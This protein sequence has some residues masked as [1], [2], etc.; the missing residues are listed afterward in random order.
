VGSLRTKTLARAENVLALRSR[1]SLAQSVVTKSINAF[2]L[3][4]VL[5]GAVALVACSS[6]SDGPVTNAPAPAD[7]SGSEA[8]PTTTK[9]TRLVDHT[10][11]KGDP[12]LNEPSP[13]TTYVP[14]LDWSFESAS[15]D[16]N[17]WPVSGSDAAIRAIPAKTG[18]YSCKVCSNGSTTDIAVSRAIGKVAA[19]HY[20]LS[21]YVRKRALTAAPGQAVA[22]IR[23]KAVI[24]SDPIDV[25]EEWDRLQTSIDLTEDTDDLTIS[26]GSDDATTG[27]C[28]FVDDVVFTRTN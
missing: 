25:R 16:C 9:G 21:A 18:S 26:I 11:A 20:T 15:P 8:D 27:N 7:T 12:S 28:L 2:G 3:S 4:I 24:T 5:S 14:L 22:R 23:G 19:G 17:G 10:P 1:S 6:E 13:A